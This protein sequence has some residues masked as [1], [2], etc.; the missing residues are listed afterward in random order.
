MVNFR[1]NHLS[2]VMIT[3]R[4]RG[5]HH[6]QISVSSPDLSPEC[7]G[8]LY[9]CLSGIS[10]QMSHRHL[11][12]HTSKNKLLTSLLSIQSLPDIY[13]SVNGKLSLPGAWAKHLLVTTDSSLLFTL[14]MHSISTSWWL[15]PQNISESISNGFHCHHSGLSHHHLLSAVLWQSPNWSS[16][17]YCLSSAQQPERSSYPIFFLF[18][19][20]STTC[21]QH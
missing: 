10:T 18:M 8:C 9:N 16:T 15:G 14:Y 20:K 3:G 17:P 2:P 6:L 4:G 12:F 1:N 19:K 21:C 11:T 13:V 7:Q 5:T